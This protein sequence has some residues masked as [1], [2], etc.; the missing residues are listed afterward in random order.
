MKVLAPHLSSTHER[1]QT[2]RAKIAAWKTGTKM[3]V[4][5]HQAKAEKPWNESQNP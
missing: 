2:G 3:P 1:Q 5:R 4:E